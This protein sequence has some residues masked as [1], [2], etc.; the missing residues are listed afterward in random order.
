MK[1]IL[2]LKDNYNS[3][4]EYYLKKINEVCDACEFYYRSSSNLRKIMT[5]YG[6]I[7]E[8]IYYGKWKNEIDTYDIIIVF[9]S[10][11]TCNLLK[12]IHRRTDARLIYWHWNPIKTK[13]EKKIIYDTEMWCE[14]WTF[15]PADSEKYRMKLNNQF[16][17]FQ[18]TNII[19]KENSAFFVGTNKKRY[20]QLMSLASILEK[21][22]ITPDFHIIDREHEGRFLE[23][24]YMDYDEVLKHLASTKVVVEIVQDNQTGLTARAL[25]AMFFNT[26][27]ITNNREIKACSFYKKE[28]IYIIGEDKDILETFL[29]T[30][31]ENIEK[32]ELYPYSAEGWIERFEVDDVL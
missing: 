23:K 10:L 32:K 11:H 29:S 4:E 19:E 15:N 20:A 25:E 17:F 30:S 22:N 3:F 18:D 31:F 7:G 8:S 16:F 24:K 9:D 28:N 2:I 27:L 1:K 13:K 14:H 5:H 6:V 26:K 12:Y 21:S